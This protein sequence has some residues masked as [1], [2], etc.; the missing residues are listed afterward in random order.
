MKQS[1]R[2]LDQVRVATPCPMK[3][4]EMD[5]DERKRFCGLC[6]LSV[7]NLSDMTDAEAEALVFAKGSDRL[8]IAYYQRSDGTILTKDCKGGTQSGR[9][10]LLLAAAVTL[11]TCMVGLVA[12]ASM[13]KAA[14]LGRPVDLPA[15]RSDAKARVANI[16]RRVPAFRVVADELDPVMI[17]GKR[18]VCPPSPT[19]SPVKP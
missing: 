14:A 2:L 8:C 11:L 6:R 9:R 17:R 19:A 16:L 18:M 13:P 15:M 7:F 3:W 10:S 4:D 5:G 1:L 12:A